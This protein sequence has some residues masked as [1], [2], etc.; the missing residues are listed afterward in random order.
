MLTV[1]LSPEAGAWPSVADFNRDDHPDYLLFNM[2][3]CDM[4]LVHEQHLFASGV[5][6]GPNL[7]AGWAVV[8]LGDF[9]RWVSHYLLFF[10]RE[11]GG[12]S[13]LGHAQ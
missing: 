7:P 11:H 6:F 5:A 1:Q 10:Q 13:C 8:V 2:E 4:D 12:N 3:L 9:Q